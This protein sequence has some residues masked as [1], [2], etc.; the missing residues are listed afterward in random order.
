M[1]KQKLLLF[2][3]RKYPMLTLSLTCFLP[4]T[5]R[6]FGHIIQQNKTQVHD[7]PFGNPINIKLPYIHA[8][9]YAE[10]NY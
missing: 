8:S 4:N 5:F 10:E 6:I 7:T 2:P 9:R 1:A 3:K